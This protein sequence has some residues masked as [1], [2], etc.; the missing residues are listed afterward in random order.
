MQI[1][2]HKFGQL[3]YFQR[4]NWHNYAWFFCF[5]DD[6]ENEAV[7][8]HIPRDWDSKT[9]KP[10]HRDSKTKKPRH[11]DSGIKTPRHW[12]MEINKPQHRNSKAFFQRTKSHNIEIP[13]LKNH[14]IE[15]PRPKS[16]DIEF[17]WNSDPYA[18]WYSVVFRLFRW[19]ST[20]RCSVFRCSGVVWSFRGCSM[21]RRSVFRCS[22]FYDMPLSNIP[23]FRVSTAI[24]F[25]IGIIDISRSVGGASWT[26]DLRALRSKVKW[27]HFSL[28]GWV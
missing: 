26:L 22:W 9:K 12:E 15:I 2:L 24:A 18:P 16:Y 23:N 20:F 25:W 3:K 14:D 7:E 19:C 1:D 11:Q 27:H 8:A 4:H 28:K 21:F 13:R 5:H 10:R 17:L 6:N